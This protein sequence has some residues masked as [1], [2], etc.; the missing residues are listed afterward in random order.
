MLLVL[1]SVE[2]ITDIF[3]KLWAMTIRASPPCRLVV[4]L[5]PLTYRVLDRGSRELLDTFL[6]L[7]TGTSRP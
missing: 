5:F 3:S 7:R 6:T 4:P 2:F 1:I